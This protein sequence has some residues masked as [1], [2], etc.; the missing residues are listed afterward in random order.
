MHNKTE[1][2][3]DFQSLLEDVQALLAATAHIAEDKVVA[4]RTRLVAALENG[5]DLL[6]D[7]QEAAVARAK[8]ADKIIRDHPYHAIGVALGAGAVL[9]LILGRR[10][11]P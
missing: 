11:D 2:T 1:P 9:G 5:R 3:L 10:T 7:A 6:D 8:A 4:A